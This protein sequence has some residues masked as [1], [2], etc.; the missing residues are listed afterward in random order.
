[1]STTIS[2]ILEKMFKDKTLYVC[3]KHHKESV[4]RSVFQS[5]LPFKE[6]VALDVDTDTLGT[7]SGEIERVHDPLTTL[8]HKV[9]MAP[10]EAELVIATEGSFGPHPSF[11]MLPA[12]DEL[13]L[14]YDKKN[15]IEIVERELTGNTNFHGKEIK[16]LCELNAFLDQVKFPEHA[17]IMMKDRDSLV[18]LQKGIQDKNQAI[19]LFE[20]IHSQHGICYIETDMRAHMNPMRMEAIGRAAQKLV[21]RLFNLCPECETPGFGVKQ[22]NLGL[23]CEI[24]GMPTSSVL[25]YT[26]SCL[27]CNF[28]DEVKYPKGQ[29]FADATYCDHC[30]P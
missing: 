18:N 11:F 3:T 27:K 12:H 7:F 15:N 8:R 30:N 2:P 9:Q 16:S 25:S 17:V 10:A 21:D 13:I 19:E 22:A 26:Y 4:I 1:M 23:P 28:T 5:K 29:R 20:H 6:V 14:F 24:C